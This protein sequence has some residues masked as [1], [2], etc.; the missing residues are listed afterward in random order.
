MSRESRRQSVQHVFFCDKPSDLPALL[1]VGFTLIA[2][3]FLNGPFDTGSHIPFL[4]ARKHD[5]FL[6]SERSTNSWLQLWS[7][8]TDAISGTVFP[9]SSPLGVL[10]ENSTK[11][12]CL[13]KVILHLSFKSS[14]TE[15]IHSLYPRCSIFSRCCFNIWDLYYSFASTWPWLLAR[16]SLIRFFKVQSIVK[17]GNNSAKTPKIVLC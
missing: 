10:M 16:L 8:L 13:F 4:L 6:D 11:Q 1:N 5:R 9:L 12:K 7:I 14:F 2:P 17:L 15:S 3:M